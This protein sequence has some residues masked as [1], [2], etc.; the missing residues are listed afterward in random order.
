M[1][2]SCCLLFF[3]FFFFFFVE[4]YK[5]KNSVASRHAVCVLNSTFEVFFPVTFHSVKADTYAL[6]SD[7]VASSRPLSSRN[8]IGGLVGTYRSGA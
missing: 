3:L 6:L 8:N 7:K 4:N 1:T 5:L 2:P